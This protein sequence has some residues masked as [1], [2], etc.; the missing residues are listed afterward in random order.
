MI[1]S[2]MVGITNPDSQEGIDICLE[3]ELERCELDAERM[4][5]R[6]LLTRKQQARQ[7]LHNGVSV[8]DI[9]KT[10]GISV[11]TVWRYVK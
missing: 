5:S 11:R 3:C 1:C 10:L 7:L 8:E 4:E 9:A 2:R 6:N